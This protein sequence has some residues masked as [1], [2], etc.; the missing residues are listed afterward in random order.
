[1]C[2]KKVLFVQ[3]RFDVTGP[4]NIRTS[5]IIPYLQDDFDIQIVSFECNRPH[6]QIANVKIDR[7]QFGFWSYYVFNKTFSGYRPKGILRPISRALSLIG[8]KIAGFPD[9]WRWEQKQLK[10]YLKEQD[11]K[12]DVIVC[13]MLPFYPAEVIR[14]LKKEGY[15]NHT[16]IV[17]DIGDPFAHNSTRSGATARKIEFER[18]VLGYADA[19][20]LTNTATAE[21]YQEQFDIPTHRITVIPQ[22]VDIDALKI[23]QSSEEATTIPHQHTDF[24]YAGTFYKDLRD[25]KYFL[26]AASS[27]S[28]KRTRFH[29]YSPASFFENYGSVEAIRVHDRVSHDELMRKYQSMD[30]LLYFDNAYGLQTSGKI[31]ELLALKKPILFIYSTEE[32]A[33]YNMVKDYSNI[34][35]CKNDITAIRAVL[36]Q[37]HHQGW[38]STRP[39]YNIS[40]FGWQERAEDYLTV[41][42]SLTH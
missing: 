9:A 20:I 18:S 17:Y 42:K 2:K 8:N 5:H 11:E 34:M 35:F 13:S 41:L 3:L 10:S 23:N 38:T 22:G 27:L 40:E 28:L 7:L 33:V 26:E 24:I 12:A 16:K 39:T 32:S 30:V 29:F 1:M 15:F 21:H 19:I 31:Y 25:P 4:R 37:L 36:Q 14:Q 6:R